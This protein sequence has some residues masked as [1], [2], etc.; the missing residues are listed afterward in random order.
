VL[1]IELNDALVGV[2]WFDSSLD[3][4]S[5]NG[6]VFKLIDD[7]S[8]GSSLFPSSVISGYYFLLA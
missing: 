7:S 8:G 5:K 3:G 6:V 4:G 1:N 2:L